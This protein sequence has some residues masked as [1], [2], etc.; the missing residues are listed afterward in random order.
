MDFILITGRTIEQGETI[1]EKCKE[2][3]MKVCATCE[4]NKKD[5]EK[6]GVKNGDIVK[7]SSNAGE[8]Y[9]YVKESDSVDEGI[10]FIPMGPW[11][12]ILVPAGTDSIGMPTFKGIKVKVEKSDGV[13]LRGDKL[14]RRYAIEG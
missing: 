13:V 1:H 11:A 3:Y 4:M 9:V 12:N 7:I 5:M 8:V 10:I 2:S 6:L 14:I